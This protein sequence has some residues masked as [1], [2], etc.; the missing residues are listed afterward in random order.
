MWTWRGRSGSW[1]VNATYRPIRFQ[2]ESTRGLG[3]V[4]T[5]CRYEPG[6][7]SGAQL[8][9]C[10]LPLN[11]QEGGRCRLTMHSWPTSLLLNT[12]PN[13]V[14]TKPCSTSLLSHNE[15][16]SICSIRSNENPRI[17]M[18]PISLS[19]RVLSSKHHTTL[20]NVFHL[21]ISPLQLLLLTLFIFSLPFTISFLGILFRRYSSRT[22]DYS[23]SSQEQ[24]FARQP[25]TTR[26][27]SPVL[28]APELRN[29]PFPTIRR[30]S[31][32]SAADVS[33]G[34]IPRE[35]RSHTD[36]WLNSGDVIRRETTENINGCRRHVMI[37]GRLG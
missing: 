3:K 11:G 17:A 30:H 35:I 19:S 29:P 15:R 33:R 6:R 27:T 34:H 2:H 32:P 20:L 1:S 22:R 4:R 37:L 13:A 8:R 21:V 25:D 5:S 12:D 36:S 14:H 7:S 10:R 9:G 18:T 16:V 31:D 26:L 23:P 28:L 24:H